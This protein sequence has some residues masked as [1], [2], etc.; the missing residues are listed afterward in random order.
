M[1]VAV[2]INAGTTRRTDLNPKSIRSREE[3]KKITGSQR[4]PHEAADPQRASVVQRMRV[5]T[6]RVRDL[7]PKSILSLEDGVPQWTSVVQ[8]VQVSTARVKDSI[9]DSTRSF[10]GGPEEQWKGVR[11]IGRAAAAC[12]HN[13]FHL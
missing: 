13:P 3:D 8:R 12:K 6:T 10:G 7:N 11:D 2:Q 1:S 5:S 4:P 9:P